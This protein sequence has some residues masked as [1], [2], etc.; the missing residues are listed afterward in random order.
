MYKDLL[1]PLLLYIGIAREV[2]LCISSE[3]FVS[4]GK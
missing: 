3:I 4:L 1:E 2:F